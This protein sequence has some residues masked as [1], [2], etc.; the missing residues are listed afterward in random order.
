M[1]IGFIEW[2]YGKPMAA[3]SGCGRQ[4]GRGGGGGHHRG[5]VVLRIQVL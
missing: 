5:V 3:S 1:L 2:A 4:C